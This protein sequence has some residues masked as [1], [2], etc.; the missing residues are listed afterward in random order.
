VGDLVSKP[1]G[2]RHTFWNAGDKPA[3]VLEV[4]S[5]GGFEHYFEEM[6]ELLASS[7]GP[8]DPP[9]LAAIATRHGLE[10]D[11]E[12]IPRLTEEYGLRW[13]PPIAS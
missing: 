1:R 4:I 13:G 7:A 8:P 2:Q 12:S 6:V 5:P 11:R 9:A 10:V 3:R